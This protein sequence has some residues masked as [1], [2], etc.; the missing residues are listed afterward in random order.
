M[1]DLAWLFG[2]RS[3]MFLRGNT[4]PLIL[5]DSVHYLSLLVRGAECNRTLL[6]TALA[7]LLAKTCCFAQGFD[8]LRVI[9]ALSS[10]YP[11]DGCAYC[12][13]MPCGC[14][15]LRTPAQQLKRASPDSEQM[16]W[17]I[18]EWCKHLN[19]VYGV[20]N[21]SRGIFFA[22][23]R[24]AQ[25]LHEIECILLMDSDQPVAS[26]SE[27]RKRLAEEFADVFAWIF[28]ITALLDLGLA[29]GEMV[30]TRYSGVHERCGERPCNCGQFPL[31]SATERPGVP[32]G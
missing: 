26:L 20:A 16:A 27:Y 32:N 18:A 6:V 12:E 30:E 7:D 23:I 5:R 17:N 21:S 25:E 10:K 3:N 31:H 4:G 24:L 1:G 11:P 13:K 9:Q 22:L 2:Q 29:L 14:A 19:R 8:D 15:Q 28:S